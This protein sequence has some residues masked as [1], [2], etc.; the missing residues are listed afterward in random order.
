MDFAYLPQTAQVIHELQAHIKAEKT[1]PSSLDITL[2]SV[3]Q[4]F[5]AEFPRGKNLLDEPDESYRIE[6]LQK[7][8]SLVNEAT[9]SEQFQGYL[10]RSHSLLIAIGE[11]HSNTRELYRSASSFAPSK[12]YFFLNLSFISQFA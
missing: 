11:A 5:L 9:D 2:G 12:K 10:Q 4:T 8:V 6:I 1:L 3:L 7:T